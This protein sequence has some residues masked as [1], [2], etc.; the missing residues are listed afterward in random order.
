MRTL[1]NFRPTSARCWPRSVA[2]VVILSIACGAPA[3]AWCKPAESLWVADTN[4]ERVVELPPS[5][6]KHSGTPS[7]L[8]LDS[9]ALDQPEGVAFDKSKNLWVTNHTSNEVLKFTPTQ[10][11]NL[12]TVSNPTAAVTISSTTFSSIDG[13]TFDHHGNLWIIDYGRDGVEELTQ[14]QLN[15]G[16]NP[17]ITPA[18]SI[19]SGALDDPNFGVF[20]KSGNL[21]VSSEDNSTVV[22]FS[23]SQLGS[24][25]NKTPNIVLGSNS[26]SLDSPGEM[27]FDKK[28]NLWVS[29]FSNSTVVMFARSQLDA[30]GSPT[31]KVTLSSSEFDGS[32]GL[33]FDSGKNLWISNYDDA[34]ASKF[35]SKQLKK[36]GAPTPPV[37]VNGGFSGPYQ[38]TFGPVF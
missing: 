2:A 32:W 14:T 22:E 18:I 35:K 17:S 37:I 6:L 19:T 16:S 10:L 20:D 3:P 1:K 34:Q 25:G 8:V 31:P 9:A 21:W 11:N 33:A 24:N 30:S 27:A 23:A 13:C 28:G 29:N 15:A 4:N 38:I 5:A 12:P 36:T 7:S 26:G